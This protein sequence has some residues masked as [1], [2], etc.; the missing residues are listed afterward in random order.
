MGSIEE[1]AGG[2][3]WGEMRN[4]ELVVKQLLYFYLKL[5]KMIVR[6]KNACSK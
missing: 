3:Q 1:K 4:E 6:V 2:Y 5:D